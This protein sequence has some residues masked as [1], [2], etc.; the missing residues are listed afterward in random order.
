MPRS[1]RDNLF[2]QAELDHGASVAALRR[3]NDN[4]ANL[5]VENWGEQLAGQPSLL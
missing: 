4:L 2:L 5:T 3:F 1:V